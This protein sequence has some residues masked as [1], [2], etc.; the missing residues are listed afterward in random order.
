MTTPINAALFT[1][2]EL[3]SISLRN[4]IVMAPLTRSRA[5][6]E[7]VP[8]LYAAEYYSDRA[9]GAGLVI[10]EATQISF[11]AQGYPRTPGAH[12]PEQMTAWKRVVDAVHEREGKIALQIW[13]CG[14]VASALNRVTDEPT[15]APSAVQ[16]KGE[17]YTDKEGMQP[18]DTPRALTVDEIKAI[19]EDFAATAE[20]AIEA[21]FDGVEIHSANGYLLN[22]FLSTNVNK[23]TD[24]YGGALE[25]RMRMPLEVVEAVTKRIGAD[26]TGI[27]IS[28]GHTFND[29][30]E[31]DMDTLYPAYI[32]ALDGYGL[33]YLHV[34]RAFANTV[35]SDVVA[36]ARGAFTGPIIACGGYTGETGAELIAAK[37]ADA[38]AFG[39]DFIANPDLPTRLKLGAPLNLPDATT[40]YTP[41]LKGYTDY[42]K[43]EAV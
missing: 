19:V 11:G 3:G 41:G 36:M 43:L 30:E 42:P 40:F 21:G 23:R 34:M 22:Q 2:V 1:P 18:H 15:V 25:N 32:K 14:R 6:D 39:R 37:G 4:R 33:A 38:I 9:E 35:S 7:G 8:S 28:P 24:A 13:H 10:A 17:M 20:R 5:D 26:K 12:T 16:A 29:I 31:A 27:R